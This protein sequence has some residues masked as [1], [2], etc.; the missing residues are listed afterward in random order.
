MQTSTNSG[1]AGL[2]PAGASP[3]VVVR[4][5]LRSAVRSPA[6]RRRAQ[7]LVWEW[8]GAKWPK[9]MPSPLDMER[10]HL[11]RSVAGQAL[12]VS[13]SGDGAVWTL[14]VA[15]SERNGPRTW[16]TQA[17]VMDAGD[18]DMVDLQTSCTRVPDA[19]LVVAPPRLLSDW[20]ERL[21]FEDAGLPVLGTPRDV[22]EEWQRDAFCEHV[23]SPQRT[24]P[25]IALVSRPNSRYYGVDPRGLAEAVSGLAH[26]ACFS[27]QMAAG[28]TDLLGPGLGLVHGAARIYAPAFNA[29][30]M[31]ASPDTVDHPLVRELTPQGDSQAQD[32]GAFRRQLVRKILAMGVGQARA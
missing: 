2:A 8:V 5:S 29:P 26:V 21:E 31:S 20:V 4:S 27:R 9:L 12:M 24:L 14:S 23:R 17:R 32:P 7:G 18:T 30:G 22:F 25:V 15:N 13:T 28:L 16:M 11:E 3:Q 19:P 10:S 6:N 1:S